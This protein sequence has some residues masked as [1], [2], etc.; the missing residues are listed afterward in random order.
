MVNSYIVYI[1]CNNATN[2]THSIPP[3]ISIY[4]QFVL[5]LHDNCKVKIQS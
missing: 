1:T 3:Y 2:G 5:P 4:L